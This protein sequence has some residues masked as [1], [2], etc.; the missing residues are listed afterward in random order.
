M[1]GLSKCFPF[2]I[3]YLIF[4]LALGG[5]HYYDPHFSDE[6]FLAKISQQD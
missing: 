5:R 6:K 4:E 3:L 1:S 2:I